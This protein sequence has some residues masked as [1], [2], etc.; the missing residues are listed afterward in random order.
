MSAILHKTFGC[1][2]K[3]KYIFKMQDYGEDKMLK[4]LKKQKKIFYKI[5]S[6]HFNAMRTKVRDENFL[7]FGYVE[8]GD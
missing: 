6:K 2:N 5:L 1:E 4:N 8:A 3:F 7:S